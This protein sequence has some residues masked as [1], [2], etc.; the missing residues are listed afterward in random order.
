[1]VTFLQ[2]QYGYKIRKTREY[3][4]CSLMADPKDVASFWASHS[5]AGM[6]R[7]ILQAWGRRASACPAVTVENS[8]IGSN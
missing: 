5:G 7:Q 6:L 1:M 3:D 4:S 8:H 2:H